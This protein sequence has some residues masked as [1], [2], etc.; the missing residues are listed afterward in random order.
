MFVKGF[1]KKITC[2]LLVLAMML[3]ATMAMA[4]E[5]TIRVAVDGQYLAFSQA[6]VIREGSTLVPFRAVFEAFNCKIEWNGTDRSVTATKDD[7]EIKLKIDDITAS[8]NGK[9]VELSVA[10]VIIGDSTMIPLRFVSEALGY[11]VYWDALGYE[12]SIRTDGVVDD[13]RSQAAGLKGKKA[14]VYFNSRNNLFR[15]LNDGT[16]EPQKLIDGF[17]SIKMEATDDYLFYYAYSSNENSSFHTLLR[18]PTDGS[19]KMG[20]RFIDDE[21]A[22][23]QVYDGYVYY[24]NT[25]GFVYRIPVNVTG[26]ADA[27]AKR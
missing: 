7:T 18:L 25:K 14:Y 15:V 4:A 13:G 24:L 20:A 19:K 27:M 17:N 10:P 3:P 5:R 26:S 22:F 1:V 6:P 21:V 8:V 16:E 2:L 11:S 12:V 23:F 9:A